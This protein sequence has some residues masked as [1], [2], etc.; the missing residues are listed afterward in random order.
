MDVSALGADE[1]LVANR[2]LW[3]AFLN[4][5]CVAGVAG[6]FEGALGGDMECGEL[7]DSAGERAD[8]EF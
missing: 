4:G 3:Q 2:F 5:E 1:A 8:V 6:G 7:C